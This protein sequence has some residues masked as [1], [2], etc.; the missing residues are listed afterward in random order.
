[1]YIGCKTV[2]GHPNF[3]GANGHASESK[4][5]STVRQHCPGL[6]GRPLLQRYCGIRDDAASRILNGAFKHGRLGLCR[7][8]DGK[9]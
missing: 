8:G 1:V 7:A 3:I 6:I 2:I 5:P 4:P 9:S